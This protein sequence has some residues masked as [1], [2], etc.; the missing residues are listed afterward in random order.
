MDLHT[1][2]IYFFVSFF[3]VIS[4]GPAVFL[5][6]YNGAVSGTKTVMASALGNIT[7]LLFLSTLSVSGLSAI[8]LSSAL[9]FTAVKVTGA[10]YLIYLGVKQ[11]L[12]GRKRSLIAPAGEKRQH[13]SLFSFYREGFLVAATNPKPILFFVA[14]FPQ[15][16][17]NHHQLF[18]QFMVMTLIFMAI[19]FSAL[20]TYGYLADKAG[21]VFSQA[22]YVHWF[23]RIS[24]G[25]FIGLGGSL[26]LVK[27]S[28]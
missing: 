28:T 1:L 10:V 25:L 4:P 19:S 7:G 23:H 12:T 20:F 16:I 17:D 8:L 21:G 26:L 2:G 14:L 22:R 5:A 9:L 15:F 24:G 27:R 3:Y 6:V 13:R 18:T 11:L